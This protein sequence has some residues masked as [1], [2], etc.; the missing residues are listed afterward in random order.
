M[1]ILS[2]KG[3]DKMVYLNSKLY[4]SFQTVTDIYNISSNV[5]LLKSINYPSS[6]LSNMDISVDDYNLCYSVNTK[7]YLLSISGNYAQ[8][9]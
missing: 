7:M 2:G 1:G 5:T 6:P 9:W 8:T 3:H 4:V